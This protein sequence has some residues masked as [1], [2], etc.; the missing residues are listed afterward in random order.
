MSH[1]RLRI[2]RLRRELASPED[3]RPVFITGDPEAT[4]L[5]RVGQMTSDREALIAN[6]HFLALEGETTGEFHHRLVAIAR[7][8]KVMFIS[9]GS[10]PTAAARYDMAGNVLH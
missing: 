2:L 8:R 10:P 1:L 7:E 9:L 3:H 4:K 6:E 5:H